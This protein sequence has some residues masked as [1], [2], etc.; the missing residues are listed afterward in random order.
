MIPIQSW[1]TNLIFLPGRV[2]HTFATKSIVNRYDIEIYSINYLEID[3]TITPVKHLIPQ[4]YKEKVYIVLAPFV[5]NVVLSII[6]FSY[7]LTANEDDGFTFLLGIYI[8]CAFAY[9]AFPTKD[10][11]HSVWLE[12]LKALK[13]NEALA[14]L[15]ILPIAFIRLIKFFSFFGTQLLFALLIFIICSLF[16]KH[17]IIH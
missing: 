16:I 5:L 12:S 17:N 3:P 9:S 8:G 15:F 6:G 13:K 10:I 7:T 2:S 14:F 11:A 1:F 4:F